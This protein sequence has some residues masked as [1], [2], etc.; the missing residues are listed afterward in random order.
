MVQPCPRAKCAHHCPA[1]LFSSST[2]TSLQHKEHSPHWRLWG[3][4]RVTFSVPP[5]SQSRP[6]SD[7]ASIIKG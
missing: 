5:I 6:V 7:L 1:G 2:A 4:I 3:F